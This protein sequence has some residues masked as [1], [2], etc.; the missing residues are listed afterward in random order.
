MVRFWA[1]WMLGLVAL[2][3]ATESI[4]LPK[5]SN[6]LEKGI[7]AGLG[8]GSVWRKDCQSRFQWQGDIE[9]S[10]SPHLS[11]SASA[12]MFGGDID[13]TSSLIYSRYFVNSRY[14]IQPRKTADLYAGMGIGFDNTS[15]QTIRRDLGKNEEYSVDAG[16]C[17]EAFDFNGISISLEAGAGMLPFKRVGFTTSNTLEIN[18]QKKL[19]YSFSLGTAVG[20]VDLWARLYDNLSSTWVHLEWVNTRTLGVSGSENSV[21]VGFSIGF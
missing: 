8:M 18:Y 6:Y 12:R 11:G 9:Y 7:Q 14:H 5:Q 13:S 20:L 2:A 1:F 15:F 19:R 3:N 10:Y 17:Q 21:L 4:P 16:T